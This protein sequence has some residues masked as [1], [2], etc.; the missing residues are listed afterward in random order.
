MPQHDAY[1]A[2]RRNKTK[3][4]I[5]HSRFTSKLLD[6][7]TQRDSDELWNWDAKWFGEQTHKRNGI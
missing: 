1:K 5:I 2:S 7:D 4:M 6:V 3:K